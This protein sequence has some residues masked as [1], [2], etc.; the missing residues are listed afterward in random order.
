M[1][2]L[3]DKGIIM[4]S[5]GPMILNRTVQITKKDVF[6]TNNPSKPTTARHPQLTL[7][8]D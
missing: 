1:G 5:F 7:I 2:V 6:A 4:G 8:T 3:G